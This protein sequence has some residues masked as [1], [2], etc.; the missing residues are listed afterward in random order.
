MEKPAELLG[1]I[2]KI[3]RTCEMVSFLCGALVSLPPESQGLQS[4]YFRER[5]LVLEKVLRGSYF[6]FNH[7][8]SSYLPRRH[9]DDRLTN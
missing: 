7:G 9:L 2:R 4:L 3:L 8:K 5:M 1:I 6:I